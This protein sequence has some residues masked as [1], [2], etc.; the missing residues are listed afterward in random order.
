MDIFG[1]MACWNSADGPSCA[2]GGCL[3]AVIFIAAL[4]LFALGL[5]RSILL[6]HPVRQVDG[7]FKLWKE[8]DQEQ[9]HFG[10]VIKGERIEIP[11]TAYN[12]LINVRSATIRAYYFAL[13]PWLLSAE[14]VES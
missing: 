6:R 12:A 7:V 4:M 14:V 2:S 11:E 5:I 9:E 1:Q 13:I 8:T 10:I 3:V